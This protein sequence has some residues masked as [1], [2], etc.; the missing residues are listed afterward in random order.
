[1]SDLEGRCFQV[2]GHALWPADAAADEF[3]AGIP[4]GRE[5]MVVI[6]RPRSPSHHRLFFGLLRKVVENSDLWQDEDELL[7]A[8][9]IAVGHTKPVQLL[10]GTIERRPRSISFASMG[11]D[12]FSRF[13]NRAAFIL[14]QF[15]GVSPETLIAET[16]A[17]QPHIKSPSTVPAAERQK[18]MAQ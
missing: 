8:V 11:Q 13:F 3:L 14:G 4:E 1:M 9:K 18:E 6:R 17:D 12:A 5:V 15:L 10:D 2:R 7:D 16:M